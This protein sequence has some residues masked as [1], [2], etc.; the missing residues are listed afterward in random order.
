M[1]YVD[2][3]INVVDTGAELHIARDAALL[4][5]LLVIDGNSRRA[6]LGRCDFGFDHQVSALGADVALTDMKVRDLRVVPNIKLHRT[7]DSAEDEARSPIPSVLVG[8]LAQ[9]GFLGGLCLLAP[10]IL[11][12]NFR[13]LRDGRR[14]DD[15]QLICSCFQL[16]LN[17]NPPFTKHV[18]GGEDQLVIEIDLGGTIQA[19]EH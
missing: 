13:R 12:G 4:A 6:L 14:E 16:R 15:E 18:I 10:E 9:I 5:T 8:R 3:K 7:P 2:G 17:F 19:F 1:R 11:G